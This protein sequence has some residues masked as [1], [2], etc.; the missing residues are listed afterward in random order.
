MGHFYNVDEELVRY[1]YAVEDP[2]ELTDIN[3][4]RSKE[5]NKIII[6]D[7]NNCIYC[8][9]CFVKN[10]HL[11]PADH[12]TLLINVHMLETIEALSTSCEICKKLLLTSQSAINCE[13]C[14]RI[15]VDV[16][17]ELT[18]TPYLRVPHTN[19]ERWVKIL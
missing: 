3:C 17:L 19:D 12:V 10:S 13:D 9:D 5:R 18:E 15:T 14:S 6:T 16:R 11:T 2:V 4:L 8:W 7:K 1:E